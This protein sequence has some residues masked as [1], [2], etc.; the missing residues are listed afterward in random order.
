MLHLREAWATVPL[1]RKDKSSIRGMAPAKHWR[2]LH[3][4]HRHAAEG[5]QTGVCD[6]QTRFCHAGRESN[7][8]HEGSRLRSGPDAGANEEARL[9][10]TG[11]CRALARKGY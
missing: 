9:R 5:N 1:D 10:H 8:V 7:H 4:H 2:K 6:T 11:D 3:D